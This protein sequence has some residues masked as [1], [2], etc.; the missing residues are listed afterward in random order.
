MVEYD[1]IIPPGQVGTVTQQ[2]KMSKLKSGT[3]TKSINVMSNAKNMDVLVL[4]ISGKILSIINI[5]H[6][7]VLLRPDSSGRATATLEL[8]SEKPDLQI[9]NITF[10]DHQSTKPK[11]QQE[12]VLYLKH[13]MKRF[14]KPDSDGYYSYYHYSDYYGEEEKA[15]KKRIIRRKT[16]NVEI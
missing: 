6:R 7:F 14:D 15:G 11:W 1:S 2:I 8:S 12:P 4:S 16:K 13:D 9:K 10:E 5:S 3:F